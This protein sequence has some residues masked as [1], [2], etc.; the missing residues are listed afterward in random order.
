MSIKVELGVTIGAATRPMTRETVERFIRSD[1]QAQV[2]LGKQ[3]AEM[4]ARTDGAERT[5]LKRKLSALVRDGLAKKRDKQRS[6][7]RAK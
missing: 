6:R 3:M 2:M 5:E 1:E 4:I 7:S